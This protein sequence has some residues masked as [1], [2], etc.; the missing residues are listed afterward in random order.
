MQQSWLHHPFIP[1]LLSLL[2]ALL[3]AWS[4]YAHLADNGLPVADAGAFMPL[5]RECRNC[6]G[7]DAESM[8]RWHLFGHS[9]AV[10]SPIQAPE[11]RLQLTLQGL[12]DID[13]PGR[14]RALI[15]DSRGVTGS[16]G[17]GDDLPGGVKIE[18]IQSDSV[19]LQRNGRLESLPLQK[20]TIDL[21]KKN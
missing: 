15:S 18:R 12:F 3:I 19:I 7:I 6:D 4:L 13:E 11:T 17:V 21:N 1:R 5:D 20:E 9:T 14:A 16:Y 8:A 2:A 10:A